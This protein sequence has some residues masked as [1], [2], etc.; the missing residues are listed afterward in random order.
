M[1][2]TVFYTPGAFGNFFKYLLNSYENK[3]LQKAKFNPSGNAHFN[4]Q[5]DDAYPINLDHAYEI[6]KQAKDGY[7]LVWNQ[8]H[9][10][11][12]L[13]SVYSRT[14]SGKFGECGVEY[15]QNNFYNYCEIQKKYKVS[16]YWH[17]MLKDIETFFNFNCDK[18]N[19]KVPRMIL[20]QL[21][22]FYIANQKQNIVT[23]R[24]EEILQSTLKLVPIDDILDYGK[25]QNTLYSL[26][27]YNID[28]SEMHSDFLVKNN[29]LKAFNL[30]NEIVDIVINKKNNKKIDCDVLTEAGV[31]YDLEKYFYDI[32]FYNIPIFFDDTDSIIQYVK[33]F[34]D[35][36]KAPNKLFSTKHYNTIK[37][38]SHDWF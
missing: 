16:D 15:L 29:S 19:P 37:R 26:F 28:F 38:I 34:P 10:F 25:L 14:N 2:K 33:S 20:R 24:N 27:D 13:H 31:L 36:M 12:I 22:F 1:N 11:L 7:G 35:Y 17:L 21:F 9:F 5:H 6:F 8:E 18:N 3:K 30:K 23:I 4:G 32:P